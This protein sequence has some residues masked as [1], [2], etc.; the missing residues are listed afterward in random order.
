MTIS[1]IHPAIYYVAISMAYIFLGGLTHA[2]SDF[3]R[4]EKVMGAIFWP[5]VWAGW[6]I[7][8]IAIAGPQLVEWNRDRRKRLRV[9]RAEVVSK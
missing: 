9:P 6:I 7:Y 2:L 4:D 8:R 5:V 3:S 1:D